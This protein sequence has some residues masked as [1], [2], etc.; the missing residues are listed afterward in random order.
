M[1]VTLYLTWSWYL[2][3]V[4]TTYLSLPTQFSCTNNKQCTCASENVHKFYFQTSKM[5]GLYQLYSYELYSWM[6]RTVLCSRICE[7]S[8]RCLI[9]GL[10][11]CWDHWDCPKQHCHCCLPLCSHLSK[12]NK[13]KVSQRWVHLYSE[14]FI[15]SILSS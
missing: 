7:G 5:W 15:C 4:L 13:A 3:L 12:E 6:V 11:Y 14:A 10:C 8:Q 1:E 2:P 9:G